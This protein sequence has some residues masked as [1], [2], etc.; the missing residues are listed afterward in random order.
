M[1]TSHMAI[2]RLARCRSWDCAA[3]AGAAS[4]AQWTAGVG[5]HSPDMVSQAQAFLP[6][7]MR[8]LRGDVI[9]KTCIDSI[10]PGPFKSTQMNFRT[11]PVLPSFSGVTQSSSNVGCK[12]SCRRRGKS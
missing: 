7:E 11:L 8:I 2:N 1:K 3:S 9:H 10:S 6:N 12:R 5:V 4:G